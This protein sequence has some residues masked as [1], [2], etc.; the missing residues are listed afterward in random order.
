[1]K[2]RKE[3]ARCKKSL[4]YV[5]TMAHFMTLNEGAWE[6]W[7]G[8]IHEVSIDIDDRFL[9]EVSFVFFIFCH[10]FD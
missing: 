3:I 5:K 6:K 2:L 10:V 8:Q 4:D 1:M 9:P 7:A